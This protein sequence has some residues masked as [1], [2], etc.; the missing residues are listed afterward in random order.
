LGVVLEGI[1]W[2]SQPMKVADFGS[3]EGVQ[4]KNKLVFLDE[5]ESSVVHYSFAAAKAK[6]I[7][8]CRYN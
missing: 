2:L 6:I 7:D 5:L 3:D 1:L 8:N 4:F